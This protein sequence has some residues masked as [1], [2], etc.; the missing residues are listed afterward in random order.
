[1]KGFVFSALYFITLM[2]TL[3]ILSKVFYHLTP[4]PHPHYDVGIRAGY[5][6]AKM[7]GKGDYNCSVDINTYYRLDMLDLPEVRPCPT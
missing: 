6:A 4:L 5:T 3:Y 2:L 1:M 7:L